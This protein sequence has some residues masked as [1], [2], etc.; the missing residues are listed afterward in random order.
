MGL[1]AYA[2]RLLGSAK[3]TLA[4]HT[5]PDPHA[6]HL[7][8]VDHRRR[9]VAGIYGHFVYAHQIQGKVCKSRFA[10]CIRFFHYYN[11]IQNIPKKPKEIWVFCCTPIKQPRTRNSQANDR[12]AVAKTIK[13]WGLTMSKERSFLRRDVLY[14]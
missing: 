14:T 12:L 8:Q 1:R 3:H 2:A 11:S 13:G 4:V 9:I 6:G 5:D 10:E 7:V